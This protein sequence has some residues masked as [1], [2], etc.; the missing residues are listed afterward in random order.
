MDADDAR[1]VL[2]REFGAEDGSFLIRLRADL[3]WDRA[4]FTRLERAMRAVC[5]DSAGDELLDRRLA[6]GFYHLATWVGPWTSHPDFPRPSP[7]EYYD[8]CLER[9][10][11]LADWYFRG[12][13]AYVEPHTWPEL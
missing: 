3:A 9:L 6:E 2:L 13:H 8:A 7:A 11:D 10:G 5:A 1:A 4:A 12:E